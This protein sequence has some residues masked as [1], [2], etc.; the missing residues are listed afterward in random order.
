MSIL[1]KVKKN[2]ICPRCKRTVSE[3]E[4]AFTKDNNKTPFGCTHC[5]LDFKGGEDNGSKNN[6]D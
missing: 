2:K 5:L 3:Y 1:D 6:Q 4:I